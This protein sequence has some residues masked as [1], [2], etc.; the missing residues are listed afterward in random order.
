MSL[1]IKATAFRF[2]L[3]LGLILKPLESLYQEEGAQL[4][5]LGLSRTE[6][7]NAEKHIAEVLE[8]VTL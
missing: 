2:L 6:D 7:I 1:K 5:T 3:L 8:F 4:L